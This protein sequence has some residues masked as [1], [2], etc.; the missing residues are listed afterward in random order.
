MNAVII[1]VGDELVTGQCVDINSAWLSEQLTAHGVD[2]VCHITLGDDVE[3]IKEAVGEALGWSRLVLITGGLGPTPDDVTRYGIAAAI[4]KPLEESSTAL[5]QIRALFARWERD[6]PES[7]RVQAQIP[8]GCSVVSNPRGSAPGIR[9]QQAGAHLFA[10]PGVPSE[11]KAMFEA[12]VVPVFINQVRTA[13]CT[14]A[15]RIHCFGMSEAKLGEILVDLM[16]RGRNPSVGTT[17]SEGILTVRVVARGVNEAEAVQLLEEDVA[18]VRSRLGH[19]VF[20]VGEDSLQQVVAALLLRQGK[21]V[22]T[23]ESCT[24]GMLAR[25]FTDIPGSSAYFL[26]GYVT[27]AN[28]AKT[29]LLGIPP[30]D[31]DDHG[32]V[33]EVVAQAMAAGCRAEAGADFA[34]STTG[35]AGPGGGNPP[36]KPV[37]LVFVGLADCDGVQVRRF[38][39]GEH[40]SRAGIRD[41]TCKWALNMLRLKLLDSGL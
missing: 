32:A 24:G 34:L 37:G 39:M 9:L 35:I 8:T 31:L 40:I 17:A 13:H 15:A 20:G 2:V 27:Y 41:R 10:L 7:N 30:S 28:K 16:A 23:A 3:R 33:S 11:M 14:K 1:S 26:R 36:E 5:E 22:A 38:L 29:E 21:T 6:M 4:G 12:A 19:I 18:E 25:R